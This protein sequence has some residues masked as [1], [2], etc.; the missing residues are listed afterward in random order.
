MS[1]RI[2]L[3]FIIK[4]KYFNNIYYELQKKY[5]KYKLKYLNAKKLYG[6][7]EQ[8]TSSFERM[9]IKEKPKKKEIEEKTSKNMEIDTP[10][11]KGKKEVQKIWILHQMENAHQEI[12]N[13]MVKEIPF[14]K[15]HLQ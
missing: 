11:I 5:L 1:L 15:K 6:G 7:M 14:L 8:L 4:K 12:L 3:I 10:E 9:E 2:L 13:V